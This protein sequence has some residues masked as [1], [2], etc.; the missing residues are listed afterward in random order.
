MTLLLHSVYVQVW[1]KHFRRRA[2]T[3]QSYIGVLKR[4]EAFLLKEGFHGELDFNQFHA[5]R[6]H[7]GR[8]LPIQRHII[9]RF[10]LHLKENEQITDNRLAA[11][12]TMLK[13][14]FE[15]LRDMGLIEQ[16]PMTNYP[17]PKC[18][19]P[20]QNTALSLEECMAVL[21]AAL[22]RDP[23]YR[24]EF[25]LIWFL[26]I[27]GLRLSE[28]RHLR[29]NRLHLDTRVAQ[30]FEGQK[31]EQ[32]PVA[33]PQDLAAEL[34]RYTTHA[35]YLK[36]ANR[37]DE[38]LFHQKGAMLSVEKLRRLLSELS[39][40]AGLSRPIRPH[41]LRRTAAYLMQKGGMHI[42]NIQHQLRHKHVGTTLRYVPPLV[43]LA[44]ILEDMEYHS[45]QR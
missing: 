16:N 39:V 8:Y 37:G 33:I 35:E 1:S 25:V 12:V 9:D 42:V 20:I 7:P 26:L 27:T 24:Q 43:D 36:H 31:T 34:E 38:Y 2:S 41:D 17:R 3:K 21:K 40:A 11:T 5:S 18:E 22:W 44:K 45:P 10:F 30:V 29:R 28:I 4:F 13:L 23:F 14:F 19:S 15:F 32:R 6:E